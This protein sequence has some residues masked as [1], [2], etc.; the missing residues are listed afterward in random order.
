MESEVRGKGRTSSS[1]QDAKDAR[2]SLGALR[3]AA[4]DSALALSRQRLMSFLIRIMRNSP[5]SGGEIAFPL[6]IAIL[7]DVNFYRFAF[8][9]RKT[10]NYSVFEN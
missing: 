6:D 9:S 10:P 2:D 7:F 5:G 1:R 8:I 3:V 4:S